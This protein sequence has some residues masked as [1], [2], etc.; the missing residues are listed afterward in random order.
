MHHVNPPQT[1]NHLILIIG[2]P[3]Y[4]THLSCGAAL[5][6]YAVLP[7][8]LPFPSTILIISLHYFIYYFL[9]RGPRKQ[10]SLPL[11]LDSPTS[12]S[13]P[14]SFLSNIIDFSLIHHSSIRIIFNM[15][16][17]IIL[18]EGR[19][20]NNHALNRCDRC[21]PSSCLSHGHWSK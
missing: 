16:G 7:N 6:P 21:L 17:S 19:N 3:L 14:L 1:Y 9:I 4:T 15:I 20:G 2:S 11:P 8:H 12:Y 10:I 5:C 18:V 13:L